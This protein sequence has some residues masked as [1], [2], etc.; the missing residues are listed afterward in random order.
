M[1]A[2]R[3]LLRA[4]G[5]S[6]LATMPLA[7]AQDA[8][9]LR[10]RHTELREQLA[11]NQFQ[12]PLYLESSEHAGDLKGEIYA[13]VEQPYRVVGPA[14]QGMD[15]WCDILIL[16]LNVKQCRV[17]T[18]RTADTLSVNI[19]RKFDQPLA[20]AYLFRFLYK[21]VAARPGY[22]QVALNAAEGPFGTSRYRITLEVVALD[23]RSSFLHMSYAYDS[24]TAARALTLA[25]LATTGRN[26]V[27]FTIVGS[28][29]DGRPIYIGSTRG[30]V[31]RN[32]MRCYLAIDAYLGALSSP[33]AEQFE[34]RLDDWYAGIER[35]PL[36]LHEMDRR[37]YLDMKHKEIARQQAAGQVAAAP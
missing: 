3:T 5:L 31:E 4:A 30:V 17:S 7:H 37:E 20:D 6:M 25:Y 15:H 26:K 21:V 29:S 9:S 2:F 36:Q 24:S 28:K 35:Y 12:R 10:A 22:L 14:L 16:Q 19:G 8:A 18:T 23:S 13:R 34:K 27:G 11:S 1:I 32:A 33:V